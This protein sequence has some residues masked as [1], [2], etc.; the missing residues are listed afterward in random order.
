MIY[1]YYKSDDGDIK[2]GG[3]MTNHSVSIWDV[4]NILNI[5][6]DEY[7]RAQGWDDWN[8]EELCLKFNCYEPVKYGDKYT[9]AE[10]DDEYKAYII[11][12]NIYGFYTWNTKAE[13]QRACD[14]CNNYYGETFLY[15]H[16]PIFENEL[17]DYDEEL[18]EIYEA[19]NMVKPSK[20]VKR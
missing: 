11:N 20:E 16:Q 17:D 1:L 9:I 14:L 3:V 6:M 4:L 5:D 15:Q 10:F 2:M 13:A 7:A 8:P 19:F 18:I 12:D